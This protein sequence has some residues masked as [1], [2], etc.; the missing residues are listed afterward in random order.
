MESLMFLKEK[1]NVD[2]KGCACADGR[3]K[4]E[5]MKKEDGASPTV[6]T[7]SVFITAV[8][9]AHEGWYVA[10]FDIPGPIFAQKQISM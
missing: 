1:R 6:S 2:I 7:E 9:Y 4:W 3:K 5:I 8:M 10:I